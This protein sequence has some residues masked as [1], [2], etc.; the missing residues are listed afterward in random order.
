[1]ETTQICILIC[2][3]TIDIHANIYVNPYKNMETAQICIY[4]YVKT[5]DTHTNIHVNPCPKYGN[6][7]IMYINLCK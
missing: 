7:I 6:N 5:I 4:I 2:V 1:M 3:Q